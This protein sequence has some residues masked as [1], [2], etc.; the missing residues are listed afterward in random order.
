MRR[1]G[2]GLSGRVVKRSLERGLLRRSSSLQPQLSPSY[3]LAA[4]SALSGGAHVDATKVGNSGCLRCLSHLSRQLLR[5][6]RTCTRITNASALQSG[7]KPGMAGGLD[8]RAH[9]GLRELRAVELRKRRLRIRHGNRRRMLC[10][11]RLFATTRTQT[12]VQWQWWRWGH[13][14]RQLLLRDDTR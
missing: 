13:G 11:L 14:V 8:D 12:V 9:G 4:D 7:G 6:V 2:S 3:L 10:G 5:L 1:F